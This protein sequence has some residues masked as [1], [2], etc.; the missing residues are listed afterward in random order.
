MASAK[1][2]VFDVDHGFMA[3]IRA[4]SRA[5]LAI[6]CG[7]ADDFSPTIYVR[8]NELDDSERQAR[9]PISKLVV[10]HPHEDHIQDIAR[11]VKC[12]KPGIIRRQRYD[13]Q[14]VEGQSEGD[15]DS[16]HQWVEFQEGYNTP[17]DDPDWGPMNV[18]H[19]SLTV[20]EAR[21][22]NESKFINNSSII[23]IVAIGSFKMTF[24]GD[25]EK[26][27]W[28]K[29]LEDDEFCAALRGT[30]VFVTSHHG[31]S[32]GYVPE[33]YDVMGKPAFNL[34]SIHRGDEN[35]EQAYSSPDRALG[36][37]WN[38]ETRYSFTTRKDGSCLVQV[39]ENGKAVVDFDD[40]G[41]N[42]SKWHSYDAHW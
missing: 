1:I 13:W 7:L 17:V 19:W 24:P 2:W 31:H 27:G 12:L 15:C 42:F 28:L 38:G 11:F 18:T 35:I 26:D 36:L 9:Y 5:T 21:A 10:T 4:P 41:V 22:L 39:D 23:T 25:I 20:G 14:E 3:F 30:S 37:T 34:S 29:K 32:S 8:E 16:L 6:D 40:L 33:I